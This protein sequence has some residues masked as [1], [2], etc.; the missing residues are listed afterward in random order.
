MP[1]KRQVRY[2]GNSGFEIVSRAGTRVIIDPYITGN[3][4]STIKVEELTPP[5][6]VL[7][8]H[9]ARDH[10]GD[11]LEIGKRSK[12]T[13]ISEPAVIQQLRNNGVPGARL[14]TAVWGFVYEFKAVHVRVVQSQNIS[15]FQSGNDMLT[16]MSVG[17]I[18]STG[19]D[20][21]FYHPGDT[22]I[23]SDIR[24]FGELY[25]PQVGLIPV[26]NA[27][28]HS[29]TELWPREAAMVCKWMHLKAAVPTHFCTPDKPREF[30]KWVKEESPETKVIV[31]KSG[32]VV[33][34]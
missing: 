1:T 29:G 8:T 15:R 21:A 34:L 4:T 10:M 22:S 11:T 2:M 20:P 5:D 23:F 26:G 9:V 14:K 17:F 24:L 32:D 19:N 6:L 18:F 13:V 7:V 12:G 25:H 28:P 30:K 31:M 3:I 27:T 33:N 16:G